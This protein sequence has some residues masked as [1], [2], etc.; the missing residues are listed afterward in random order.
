[1]VDLTPI[2]SAVLTLIISGFRFPDSVYQSKDQRRTVQHY[3][4]VGS[5]RCASG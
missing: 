3:Q 4:A 5:D 2:I 1:M